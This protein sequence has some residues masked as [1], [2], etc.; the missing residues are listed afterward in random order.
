MDQGGG[1]QLEPDSLPEWKIWLRKSREGKG[2]GIYRGQCQE[3]K[4]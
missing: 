4:S 1:A 2:A 3:G